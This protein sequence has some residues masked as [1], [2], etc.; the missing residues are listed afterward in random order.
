HLAGHVVRLRGCEVHEKWRELLRLGR[1]PDKRPGGEL[2]HR[3]CVGGLRVDR[4]DVLVEPDPH[5]SLDD[6]GSEGIDGDAV[7]DQP[8]GSRLGY[9]ESAELRQAMRSAP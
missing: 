9:G 4:A 5:R 1:A 6:A 2:P 3:V 8:T 7:L